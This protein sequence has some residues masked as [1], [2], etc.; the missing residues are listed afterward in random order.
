MPP[1]E[2]LLKFSASVLTEAELLSIFLRTGTSDLYV[3]EMAEKLILEFCLLY[4]LML[5][6]YETLS[7]QKG[8]NKS[9]FL[10]IQVILE[11][12]NL[13]FY[14]NLLHENMILNSQIHKNFCEIFFLIGT[15]KFFSFLLNNNHRVV[16]YEELFSGTIDTVEGSQE[17]YY[18]RH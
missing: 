3:S 11:L 12:L 13:Y 10:Q 7:A 8:M 6:N 2:K 18:E 5:A 17:K 4:H 1:R 16:C 15:E 14:S 9:K